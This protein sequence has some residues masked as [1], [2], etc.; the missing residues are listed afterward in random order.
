MGGN[1]VCTLKIDGKHD[2]LTIFS[3]REQKQNASK[4]LTSHV[5]LLTTF[6]NRF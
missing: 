4:P 6:S 3:S 1:R 2:L 5:K